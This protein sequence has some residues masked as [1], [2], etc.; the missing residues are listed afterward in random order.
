M[1][2]DYV[3]IAS[4]ENPTYKDFYPIVAKKWFELGYK[5]YY[6]NI[7]DTDEILENKWGIIHNIKALD[8]VSTAFQSQVVRLFC[9][10]FIEG[11]LLMSDIDMLPINKDYYNSY[12]D[13]LTESNVIIY[14]GQPYT[15]VPY[16]PMC[17]ILAHS[18]TLRNILSIGNLRFSDYCKML[19][20]KYGEAWNTDEHFMYD[21]FQ[22]NK[23]YLIIKKR[24]LK[25]R[26]DRANWTYDLDLLKKGHYIDSHLLRPYEKYF[27]KINELINNTKLIKNEF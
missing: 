3:I 16:Y 4:D 22:K 7:C 9:S 15:D 18:K 11:N 5:T 25:R 8:F 23:E 2:I 10:N 6:V 24:D 13:E 26:V 14:T 1:K 27:Q 20:E 19:F 17:Y 21:E 12:L